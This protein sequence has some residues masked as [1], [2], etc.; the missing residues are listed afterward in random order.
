MNF[1]SLEEKVWQILEDG[2]DEVKVAAI[3]VFINREAKAHLAEQ[4]KNLHFTNE[5]L[6]N[7]RYLDGLAAYD[8][9]RNDVL[10]LLKGAS[11]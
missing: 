9:C 2:P 4:V 3:I 8:Q 5:N 1:E 6:V 10:G 7:T 11:E